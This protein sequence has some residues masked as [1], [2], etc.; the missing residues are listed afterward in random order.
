MQSAAVG[1]MYACFDEVSY[2]FMIF[3]NIDCAEHD[4]ASNSGYAV[5]EDGYESV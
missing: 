1:Y 3:D 4:R 5:Q 2:S